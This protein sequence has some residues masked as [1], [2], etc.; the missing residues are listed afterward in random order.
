[1]NFH[2]IMSG[3][4]EVLLILLVSALAIKIISYGLMKA[5]SWGFY[6]GHNKKVDAFVSNSEEVKGK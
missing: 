1:M 2:I 5:Y 3:M 6:R 4:F